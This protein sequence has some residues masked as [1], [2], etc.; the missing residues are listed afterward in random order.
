MLPLPENNGQPEDTALVPAG[1][2]GGGGQLTVSSP[3][4]QR[5]QNEEGFEIP[6]IPTDRR[7]NRLDLSQATTY[8]YAREL[9]EIE[10]SRPS[11]QACGVHVCMCSCFFVRSSV[12]LRSA[13]C[14]EN[15]R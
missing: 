7:K 2:A 15:E 1:N 3:G 9:Q 11:L 12:P 4:K 14:E 5:P 13:P 6:D 10:V 8:Q